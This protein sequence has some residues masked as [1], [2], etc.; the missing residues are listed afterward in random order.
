MTM[1]VLYET[2]AGYALF[3]VRD[4]EKLQGASAED[5][6]RVME[7]AGQA[8]RALK[9][10]AFSKF[11]NTAEAVAAA[12]DVAE[13][14][15]PSDLKRF[16]RK[17]VAADAGTV[18][19]VGDARLGGA[20][21]KKLGVAVAADAGVQELLRG[22]RAQLA[23]LVDGLGE[24]ELRA[25]SL[26][27]AH[28]LSRHRI[29]FSPDKVDTMV[30]QAVA[31]LDDL[32]RELNTYAMRLREWYGWH[33]PELARV[34]GDAVA[35]AR[36]V[37]LM[38]LRTAAAST[39]LSP[40]LPPELA[41]E[42]RAAAALSMGTEIAP[43]DLDN[44]SCLADQVIAL[45]EY[46]AELHEYLRGRMAAIAP[47]LTAMVGELVGARLIA[48]AGSL[49]GLAKHPASTVQVLGAEKA[50]VLAIKTK[51]D[52]PKYGL[53]YHASIVGQAAP[54]LK[55]KISRVLAARTALSVR[56][57]ALAEDPSP[58]VGIANRIRVENRLRQLEGRARPA[59]P[60]AATPR[61][62]TPKAPAPA[63]IAQY[64]AAAD[65]TATPKP[66]ASPAAVAAEK[67]RKAQD[68]P[69]PEPKK[70]KED[71]AEKRDKS[72]K[73]DKKEKKEKKEKKDKDSSS[74]KSK[75]HHDSDSD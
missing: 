41:A 7:D 67:K 72:E 70:H 54:R 66:A 5:V 22:V 71:K 53:I 61:A 73:S 20:I 47:N 37:R 31:L 60:K 75:K 63:P 69:V 35:Y 42:V 6:A 18:L 27:L 49:I 26:G 62:S 43:E 59:T 34:L 65:F 51:H 44:I 38:G 24:G 52:T 3:A 17:H 10:R 39:D 29:R 12:T 56:V 32:D 48:R 13:G 23:T 55:G 25:M 16:L 50:L 28:S 64:N 45:A 40:V 68:A 30:V 36:T 74:H 2:A 58:D 19:G 9:L 57:D 4:G 8:P 15:L 11:A 14:R 46:R 33:F 21:A 1:L